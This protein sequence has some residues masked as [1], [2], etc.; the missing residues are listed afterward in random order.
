MGKNNGGG[1]RGGGIV[2]SDSELNSGIHFRTF[3]YRLY[4][5][6]H[7][8]L[9][10]VMVIA[11][12]AGAHHSAVQWVICK[13]HDE[14]AK[15]NDCSEA[16]CSAQNPNSVDNHYY[17]KYDPASRNIF[18]PLKMQ[19]ARHILIRHDVTQ[20]RLPSHALFIVPL[21]KLEKGKREQERC[22][23]SKNFTSERGGG[24]KS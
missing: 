24:Q 5:T 10:P 21:L 1:G 19:E 12:P 18:C 15:A 16:P 7:W 13:Q 20:I 3:H 11:I 17:Y 22:R 9:M 23:C 2:V 4:A 6:L 8:S 14:M